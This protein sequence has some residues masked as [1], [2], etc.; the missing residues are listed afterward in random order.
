MITK[1]EKIIFID[2]DGVVNSDKSIEDSKKRYPELKDVLERVNNQKA[3]WKDTKNFVQ[4]IMICQEL[5]NNLLLIL[6]KF[7]EAHLVV[8]S[9]WGRRWSLEKIKEIFEPFLPVDRLDIT[10]KKFSSSKVHEVPFWLH[11]F[12]EKTPNWREDITSEV[13][14]VVIIDDNDYHFTCGK[15]FQTDEKVGLTKEDAQRIIDFLEDSSNYQEVK[16]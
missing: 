9:N 16:S 10:P 11:D 2:F 8:S 4:K 15:F 3:S 5:I 1:N 7:P 12:F 14:K 6:N 13:H